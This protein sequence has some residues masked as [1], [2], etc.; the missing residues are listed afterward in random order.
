MR[1]STNKSFRG[2]LSNKVARVNLMEN[3][4]VSIRL[5]LGDP[6]DMSVV[7]Q[8]FVEKIIEPAVERLIR[9]IQEK[10]AK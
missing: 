4:T 2:R 1:K 7:S 8:E 9:E 3:K 5:D 10:G 6:L